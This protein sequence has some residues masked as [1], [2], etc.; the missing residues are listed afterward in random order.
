MCFGGGSQPQAPTNPAP[1]ALEDASKQ[2]VQTQRPSEVEEDLTGT[3][4]PTQTIPTDAIAPTVTGGS[5]T[6]FT[7]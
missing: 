3:M 5:G 1:Y 7:M 4:T 6:N 2:V